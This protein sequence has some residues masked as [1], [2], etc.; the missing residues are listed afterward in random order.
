MFFPFPLRFGVAL[1]VFS[2]FIASSNAADEDVERFFQIG[3]SVTF[4]C[5]RQNVGDEDSLMRWA[6]GTKTIFENDEIT[7]GVPN[8]ARYRY[9]DKTSLAIP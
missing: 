1:I 6:V 2:S 7:A 9:T 3:D 4:P 5:Q 8:A